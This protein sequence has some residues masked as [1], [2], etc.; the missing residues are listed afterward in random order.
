MVCV[1]TEDSAMSAKKDFLYWKEAVKSDGTLVRFSIFKKGNSFFIENG[2]E[3]LVHPSSRSI[4]D[5]I[6]IVFDAKVTKTI[7]PHNT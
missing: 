3:H 4:D 7:M 6:R 2:Y 5:E 1:D